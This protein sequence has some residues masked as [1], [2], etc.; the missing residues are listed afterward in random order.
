[1]R[2]LYLYAGT[3]KKS[4]DAWQ[5]GL[6]PDTPLIGLNHLKHYGID[7]SFFENGLTELF[8]RISFNLTQLPALFVMRSYDAVFSGAGLAT[9]FMVKCLFG[10]KKP[11]WFI[12]NTYLSNLLKRNRRGVKATLVRK[13][14]AAADGIICPS[15]SQRD[16]LASEG[17]DPGRLF[18]IP[19]G[20]DTD[21][22]LRNADRLTPP[23]PERYVFSAGRDMGRDYATLIKAVR[24]QNLHLVIGA[25]PR[26]F[27]GLAS[28]PPNVTVRYFP[29]IEM[30]SLFAHAAF[31]VI[32]SIPEEKLVGSDCSGQYV[33]LEAMASGKA[34]VI[35]Q[36]STRTDHFTDGK[37]GLTV[38]PEDPAALARAIQTLWEDPQR[39]RRMG[40]HARA[41]T[42]ERFTTRRFAEG[43]A[44][45]LEKT[46]TANQY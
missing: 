21:F 10:W 46:A 22:Y 4:F 45:I 19:Y 28:F 20:I 13:A 37:D 16:Y 42:L 33:L 38:P 43:F 27:S 5:Q 26:N 34:V 24:G 14:I 11:R 6:E 25:L 23:V 32:P 3:R 31:I 1:M 12:Y 40:E 39:A 15:L 41:K 35:T 44:R 8:R 36:R 17:F 18:H 9:L 29:Q 2:V 30:P 7:A